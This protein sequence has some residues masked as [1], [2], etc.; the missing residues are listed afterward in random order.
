MTKLLKQKIDRL[1]SGLP[2]VVIAACAVLMVLSVIASINTGG[3][4]NWVL[5]NVPPVLLGIVNTA[6]MVVIYYGYLKGM[7]P[8]QKPLTVLWWIAIGLNLAGF[9]TTC[10]GPKYLGLGAAVAALLPLVYLPL[11]ILIWIW[12][13]GKLE[14]V[15]IWMIVRILIMTL[16]PVIFYLLG[17]ADT[18]AGTV[19]VDVL[20]VAADLAYVWVLMRVL[21]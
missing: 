9:V 6:G 20:T 3:I 14:L 10:L 7:K 4:G 12:Y 2:L 18:P 21:V 5:N 15:G 1:D 17:W 13:G 16:V 8:L 19:I 11:G